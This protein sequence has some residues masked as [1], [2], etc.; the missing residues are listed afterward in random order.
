MWRDTHI[1]LQSVNK[2]SSRD[3]WSS[4]MRKC[5]CY[6]RVRLLTV[7]MRY[8]VGSCS[9]GRRRGFHSVKPSMHNE[10][11]FPLSYAVLLKMTC[12]LYSIFPWK[13]FQSV[14][15]GYISPPLGF[16]QI[17][18]KISAHQPG[19]WGP[20]INSS[21]LC[22]S[23]YT[24]KANQISGVNKWTPTIMAL[25]VRQSEYMTREVFILKRYRSECRLDHWNVHT[26]QNKRPY[27]TR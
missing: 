19:L 15:D 12:I 9:H 5:H 22:V 13:K 20:A 3:V 11:R 25:Q 14:N 8:A 10:H 16:K 6:W 7:I 24:I 18:G 21:W 23:I 27:D 26:P 17:A 2:H 1:M 4:A